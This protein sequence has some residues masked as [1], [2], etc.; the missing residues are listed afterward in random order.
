MNIH[1]NLYKTNNMYF[2]RVSAAFAGV[3]GEKRRRKEV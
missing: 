2:A 1:E 3:R